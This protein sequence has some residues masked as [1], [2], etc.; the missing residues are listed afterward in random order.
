MN[1]YTL[2]DTPHYVYPT[3]AAA[4]AAVAKAA[5][6][7]PDEILEYVVVADPQGTGKAVVKVFDEDHNYLGLF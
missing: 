1:V 7:V 6:I 2:I 4:E 5:E 3:V